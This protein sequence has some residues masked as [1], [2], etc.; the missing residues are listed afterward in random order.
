MGNIQVPTHDNS[1]SQLSLDHQRLLFSS[2][3]FTLAWRV[4]GN[5]TRGY[6]HL[7]TGSSCDRTSNNTVLVNH[8]ESNNFVLHPRDL[9]DEG[10]SHFKLT[11]TDR[12]KTDTSLE[13]F[14]LT[15][16]SE[17]KTNALFV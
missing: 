11:F 2:D 14:L 15:S 9:L 12:N 6:Y 3:S 8:T 7:T 4:V 16:G 5:E 10:L 1:Q 13:T 17:L